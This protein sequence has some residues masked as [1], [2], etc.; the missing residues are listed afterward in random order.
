MGVRQKVHVQFR[1][2]SRKGGGVVLITERSLS[3][4]NCQASQPKRAKK[5]TDSAVINLDSRWKKR[6]LGELSDCSR[7]L[8]TSSQG[9]QM[10]RND[11]PRVEAQC[12]YTHVQESSDGIRRWKRS[13]Y[14]CAVA[15][16]L[17]ASYASTSCHCCVAYAFPFQKNLCNSMKSDLVNEL[18]LRVCFIC[19]RMVLAGHVECRFYKLA[20]RNFSLISCGLPL[21]ASEH[22]H[23]RIQTQQVGRMFKIIGGS[24]EKICKDQIN[25]LTAKTRTEHPTAP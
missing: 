11:S 3:P 22:T 9:Q 2:R 14:S 10:S 17:L 25:S 23:T 1:P 5:A 20:L 24:R 7:N 18:P 4:S 12:F 21:R 16:T 13:K 8:S 19:L 15:V 6:V